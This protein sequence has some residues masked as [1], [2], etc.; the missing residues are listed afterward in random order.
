MKLNFFLCI[1]TCIFLFGCKQNTSKNEIVE[2]ENYS[3]Q[4]GKVI[5]P[6]ERD[7]VNIQL[8]DGF[9]KVNIH[10]EKNQIVFVKFNSANYTNLYALL[11]SPDSS[12]NIRFSQ[13]FMP[14]GSMDGPFGRE[15]RYSLIQNENYKLSIHEN[16]MAGDPWTGDFNIEISLE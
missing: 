2:P 16:T 3:E 5:T 15:I 4:S 12:A 1:I 13:I 10:K 9:G 7:T 11:Y 8:H 6:G 14:D